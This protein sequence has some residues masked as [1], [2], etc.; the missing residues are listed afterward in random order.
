MNQKWFKLNKALRTARRLRQRYLRSLRGGSSFLQAV[1]RRRLGDALQEIKMIRTRS[2]RISS[3]VFN[4]NGYSTEQ[5]LRDFR[6]RPQELPKITDIINWSGTTTRNRYVVSPMTATCILLRR[7]AYPTRWQDLEPV[8]G[9]YASQLS[10]VF[11]ECAE[12]LYK[13]HGE[14]VTKFRGSLLRQRA[15]LYAAAIHNSGGPLD[16]CVGFIDGTKLR[17]SRPGGP[18]VIQQSVY[19]GHKRLHCL[20][21]QTITTPDGLIFHIHGPVEGRRSDAFLYYESELDRHLRDDLKIGEKQYCIYGDQAYVLRPWMQVGFPRKRATPEQLRYNNK[22]N[23]ARIAVE[24]SYG[25]VK[26]SWASQDYARKLQTGKVPVGLL[27]IICV[28]LRNFK[29]CLGHNTIAEGHFNCTPP[30]LEEYICSD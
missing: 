4:V 30:S 16:N 8:F 10:E 11:Y 12:K 6:F 28:L 23:A 14:L 7:L 25:E 24:W 5:C 18:A 19:S 21:F 27:Y 29:T 15:S 26:A 17:I 9:L 2:M 13:G 20:T 1:Y 3:H 22:M